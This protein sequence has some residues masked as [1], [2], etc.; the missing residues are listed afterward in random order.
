MVQFN[1]STKQE[2]L[3]GGMRH[4]PPPPYVRNFS[5]GFFPSDNF[6][7]GIFPSVNFQIVQFPQRQLPNSVQD[8]ALGPNYNMRRLRDPKLTLRKL[9]FGKLHIWEVAVWEIV[10]WEVAL[11]KSL[12]LLIH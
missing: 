10:K 11:G 12:P 7:S 3:R 5:K 2:P 8:Q 6:P 4:L 9:P 1:N